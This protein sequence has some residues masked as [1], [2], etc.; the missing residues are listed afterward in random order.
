M[1]CHD[2]LKMSYT[3]EIQPMTRRY[4][5]FEDRNNEITHS[6]LESESGNR[7]LLKL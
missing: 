3:V 6:S 4:C 7:I 5:H 1:V 2:W